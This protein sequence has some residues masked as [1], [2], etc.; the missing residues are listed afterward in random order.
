M[1]ESAACTTTV[2]DVQAAVAS[3]LTALDQAELAPAT[4]FKDFHHK[5]RYESLL[6][7]ARRRLAAATYHRARIDAVIAEEA[8][9]M[10]AQAAASAVELQA[11]PSTKLL[12]P[13][14]AS[15]TSYTTH[16]E[17]IFELGAM[18]GALRSAVDF[19]ATM[20][21]MHLVGRNGDSVSMMLKWRSQ[22][23]S[24]P[25]LDTIAPHET[26]LRE[27]RDYRDHIVH[28]QAITAPSG[29]AV[30]I[31]GGS[32][33]TAVLPLVIPSTTPAYLPDTRYA[34]M[35][36]AD[37]GPF[38]LV[39]QSAMAWMTNADGTKSVMMH[40]H[41]YKPAPGFERVTDLADRHLASFR[42]FLTHI[43]Q[44]LVQIGFKAHSAVKPAS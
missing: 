17:A 2:N 15:A 34:Q 32:V 27:L 23:L 35:I 8:A 31:E 18:L 10:S 24:A 6:T 33:A 7:F 41:S 39:E 20:S 12:K 25:I 19:L 30:S 26:W 37:E 4:L 28:K 36:F 14:S 5:Q 40:E 3:L 43:C 22:G 29:F 16:Q 42:G 21:I 13:T 9:A 44:S 38:G 11:N 1:T